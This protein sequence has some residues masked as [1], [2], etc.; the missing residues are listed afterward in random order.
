MNTTLAFLERR[1]SILAKDLGMPG[2]GD[3][4]LGRL[5]TI[6]ARVP[7]H[8]R[9]VPWRFV[10]LA[11][12]ARK[13]A[14]AR[15]AAIAREDDRAIAEGR[16]EFERARFERAPVVVCVVSRAAPHPKIPEWEQLLSAGAACQMLVT[17]AS[18]M[19]FGAQWLTEWCAYDRRARSELGLD[20]HERVAGFVY[21]GTARAA[22][23]ERER[24]VMSNIV[25]HWTGA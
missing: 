6:A 21:I 2:P 24:P 12:D 23:S 18:A 20:E 14:G 1:R 3:E 22:P 25:T 7:D 17:A 11:G 5:L 10:V 16:L 13:R 8:G 9:L 15:M 4:Q 19:G